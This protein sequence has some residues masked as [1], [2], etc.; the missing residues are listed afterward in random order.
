MMEHHLM[1]S[2]VSHECVSGWCQMME[3]TLM[4]NIMSFG[5]DMDIKVCSIIWHQHGLDISLLFAE[6]SIWQCMLID[7][8]W[9]SIN[10]H[11]HIEGSTL[12]AHNAHAHVC[13]CVSTQR[14]LYMCAHVHM[15]ICAHWSTST[16]CQ[17]AMMP[18]ASYVSWHH[19]EV[20]GEMIVQVICTHPSFGQR[21]KYG[22]YRAQHYHWPC[23]WVCACVCTHACT[24]MLSK[25]QCACTCRCTH[26]CTC[27]CMSMILPVPVGWDLGP[28][29]Q[30]P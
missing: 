28:K 7:S 10:M 11:C 5:H 1:A 30:N 6:H 4:S 25:A 2:C 13:T 27:R 23:M 29:G 16:W 17:E 8:L 18:L 9:L 14:V 3:H 20:W 26:T 19:V 24:C 21:S 22:V 15:C 12:W